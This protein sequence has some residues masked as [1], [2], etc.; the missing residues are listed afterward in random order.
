[1]E[2]LAWLENSALSTWIRTTPSI[3]G[4]VGVL[5]VHTAG[6]ALVVGI[7]IIVDL[8][9]LGVAADI[10]IAGFDRF[11]PVVW[12]G[13]G[14]NICSGI[15]LFAQDATTRAGNPM[16]AIKLLLIALALG[17]TLLIQRT[18]RRKSSGDPESSGRA[19]A[20]ASLVLWIG[21]TTAGR[22]MA[23]VAN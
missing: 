19:L 8:R 1:M 16:F 4:Y 21:V 15:V 12:T 23:Y 6:F 13:V 11:F 17:V 10:P 2:F 22:M 9:L 3:F 14:L 7:S 20:L 18:I 5:F